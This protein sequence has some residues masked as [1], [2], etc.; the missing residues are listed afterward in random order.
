MIQKYEEQDFANTKV[1]T[2][3]VSDWNPPPA[4]GQPGVAILFSCSPEEL[5]KNWSYYYQW[6]R[7]FRINS[8]SLEDTQVEY[9][10]QKYT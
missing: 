7:E 9:I 1:R 3:P 6:E 10:S 4:M 5:L 2:S 8:Q